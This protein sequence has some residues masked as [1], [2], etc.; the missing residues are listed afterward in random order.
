MPK[1]D[2]NAARVKNDTCRRIGLGD[3]LDND[4]VVMEQ[5]QD[6]L[7]IGL[8]LQPETV[9]ASLFM[10]WHLSKGGVVVLLARTW[11]KFIHLL[12]FAS[13]AFPRP[14][15]SSLIYSCCRC[16]ETILVVTLDTTT[17]TT[18]TTHCQTTSLPPHHFST[19]H[20]QHDYFI[21]S[22][23]IY[24]QTTYHPPNSSKKNAQSHRQDDP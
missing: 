9:S 18:T 2:I 21:D 12:L 17:T 23:E 8:P 6:K 7:T 24:V 22:R 4:E 10:W 5:Y 14:L 19:I 3:E 15:A 20:T 11:A 1:L 13:R 16:S